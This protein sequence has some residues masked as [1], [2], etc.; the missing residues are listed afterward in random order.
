MLPRP[1]VPMDAA[2]HVQEGGQAPHRPSRGGVAGGQGPGRAHHAIRWRERQLATLRATGGDRLAGCHRAMQSASSGAVFVGGRRVL[3]ADRC[4][5][6]VCSRL[7]SH[8]AE[9]AGTSGDCV[10]QGCALNVPPRVRRRRCGRGDSNL[11]NS[12][13]A[14]C[15]RIRPRRISANLGQE[16]AFPGPTLWNR[17]AVALL[18]SGL[19]LFPQSALCGGALQPVPALPVFWRR[20]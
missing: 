20:V 18:G 11:S 3:P 7:G 14:V 9:V 6:T 2:G 8:A 13:G 15:R 12:H 5:H 1:G 4:P 17:N 10:A 19:Q 16:S